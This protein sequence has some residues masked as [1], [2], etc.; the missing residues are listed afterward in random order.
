MNEVGMTMEIPVEGNNFPAAGE[1]AGKIKKTLLRL[2]IDSQLIRRVAIAT[3]EAEMNIVIH[4]DYGKIVLQVDEEEIRV[5][6]EDRG[7]G[8]PDLEL[9]MRKGYST[10]S[11]EVREMGFG[12]G[13]GLPNIKK[14]ADRLEIKTEVNK[15][16]TVLMSFKYNSQ[17][18]SYHTFQAKQVVKR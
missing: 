4:S 14:C 18:T 16:T 7:N 8:I 2:G 13:M 11:E 1:A 9:A 15:G 10:A 12:A 6:A 5:R 17:V 3:Y